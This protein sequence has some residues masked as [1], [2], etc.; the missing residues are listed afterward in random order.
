MKIIKKG[1]IKQ[2]KPTKCF[3]C[4]YCGCEFIAEYDEYKPIPYNTVDGSMCECPTCGRMV[5]ST[6]TIE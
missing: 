1:S 4:N 6:D 2:I 3:I 5:H